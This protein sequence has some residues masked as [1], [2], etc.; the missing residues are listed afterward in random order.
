MDFLI[1][2][3]YLVLAALAVIG[4]GVA[5]AVK[6]IKLP[7]GERLLWLREKLFPEVNAWLLDAVE[8]AESYFTS[9][10]GQE[11]LAM[12][13]GWFCTWFPW[14]SKVFPFALFSKLVDDALDKMRDKLKENA[15]KE[16]NLEEDA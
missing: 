12:V 1:D 2:Y 14:L 6:I 8:E 5:F 16:E 4:V 15:E 9:G 3:W 11:K 13:Y 7:A 10:H